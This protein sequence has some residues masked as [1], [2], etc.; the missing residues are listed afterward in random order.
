M[1][2][3]IEN[4]DLFKKYNTI[5]DEVSAD[6]KKE[7]F[8]NKSFLKTKIKSYSDQVTEFYD[9]E[10][11]KIDFNHTF[12]AVIILDSALKKDDNFILPSV[13]KS[14]RKNKSGLSKPFICKWKGDKKT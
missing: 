4:D 2:F 5:W 13:F 8:Y 10:I 9:K 14:L 11:P 1:C 6:I 7:P 3:L 12:L